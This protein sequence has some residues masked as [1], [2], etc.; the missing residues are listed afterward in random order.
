MKIEKRSRHLER[1]AWEIWDKKAKP[2]LSLGRLES[3]AVEIVSM[4]GSLRPQLGR[5]AL[6]LFAS[7]HG[8]WQA[9]VSSSPQEI[10][11]QQC[12]NFAHGGGAIG[13]MCRE[14]GL[15]LRV[16]DM[17]VNYDFDIALGIV[18]RKIAY[19]TANFAHQKALSREQLELALEAGKGEVQ[20]CHAEGVSTIAF[21]EMGVG[22]TASASALMASLTGYSVEACTG[23]GAGLSAEGLNHKCR[24]LSA[25]L[26]FH[27]KI[28]DPLEVLQT[29]GGFEIAAIVGGM[30]QAASL[31]KVI[32]V[33]GF[34]TSI[35]ALIAIKID[36][37]VK[38]Y[39]IFCH[40]SKESGH[41]LLLK[42]MEVTPLLSLSMCL[43]EGS[44][45]ALAWLIIKQ[46]MTLFLEMTPFEEAAVTDSVALLKKQGVDRH[47]QQ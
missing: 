2:Q 36:E 4:C 27:G 43:G 15:D 6:L 25:A 11:W 45:A 39:L 16:I 12:V 26:D 7:D 33:D 34:I 8:I 30:L 29:F 42:Y 24:V 38:D 10:T 18:N 20:R 41:A 5:P 21:G 1:E 13:L 40:E 17:G 31:K 14:N 46:A 37:A 44:G 9:G 32:L 19:S 23:K 35:A 22:N 47:A 3:L 28:E